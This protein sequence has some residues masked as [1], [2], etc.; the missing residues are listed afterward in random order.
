MSTWGHFVRGKT[1][2][3]ASLVT[4]VKENAVYGSHQ[5]EELKC[6]IFII[7]SRVP[8]QLHTSPELQ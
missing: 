6:I 8:V 1:S 4:R 5:A 7:H 3:R 2:A